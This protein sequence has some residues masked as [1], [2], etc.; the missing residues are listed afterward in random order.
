M[1]KKYLYCRV[2]TK[3]QIKGNSLQDQ[4]EAMLKVYGD[5]IVVEEQYSGAKTDRPKFQAIL[6]QMEPGDYLVVTKLDRMARNLK[7][8]LSV[9]DELMDKGCVVHILNM[10]PLSDTPTGRLT[11]QILLAFAEFERA[12]IIERT[13]A[14][15]EI[16]RQKPGYREGRKPKYT[17]AQYRTVDILREA[18]QTYEEIAEATGMSRSAVYRHCQSKLANEIVDQG[19]EIIKNGKELVQQGKEILDSLEDDEIVDF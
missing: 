19:I 5:G 17:K 3:T 9:I 15:K 2:S 11:Y 7:E 10:G 14:G 6:N 1:S 4:A 13:T 16:A 12:M 18:G 8:G